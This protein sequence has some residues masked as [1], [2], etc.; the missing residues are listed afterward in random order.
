M[1]TGGDSGT[2]GGGGNDKEGGGAG[3][4][5]ET[6]VYTYKFIYNLVPQKFNVW[7]LKKNLSSENA[8]SKT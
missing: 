5:R 2:R 3:V 8:P 1:G 4:G 6:S 7:P